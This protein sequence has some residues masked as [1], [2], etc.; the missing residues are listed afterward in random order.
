MKKW[1][2]INKLAVQSEKFRVDEL[3]TI[4]LENRGLETQKEIDAFLHSD[5]SK[6][7]PKSVGIDLAQLK[8]TV[9]RIEKA[10]TDREQ[11]IVFGDYD[12]DGITASAIL[13][14]TLYVLGAKLIPY[15]PDRKAEGYGLSK[16]GIENSG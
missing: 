9:S 16:S 6:V 11:I 13:W 3:I 5:L 1:E 14:E 4:L 8:K 7:T 12:V 15:I 2:T 10:I